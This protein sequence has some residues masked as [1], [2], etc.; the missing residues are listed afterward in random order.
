M[1]VK[2]I[3]SKARFIPVLGLEVEPGGVFD[4]PDDLAASLLAQTDVYQSPNPPAAPAAPKP[5]KG[6]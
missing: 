6:A 3:G 1:E 5:K 2:L 4:A